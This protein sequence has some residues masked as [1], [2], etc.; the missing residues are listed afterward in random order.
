[1]MDTGIDETEGVNS[2]MISQPLFGLRHWYDGPLASTIS[3][4][5]GLTQLMVPWE[6]G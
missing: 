4:S 1:M 5:N 6:S 3:M 2:Q